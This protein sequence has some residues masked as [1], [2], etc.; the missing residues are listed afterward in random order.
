M[1]GF[2]QKKRHDQTDEESSPG[3]GLILGYGGM[4]LLWCGRGHCALSSGR[5]ESV[6]LFFYVIFFLTL[7]CARAHL[8]VCSPIPSDRCGMR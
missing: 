2:I 4:F 3:A 5:E 1:C 7:L 6:S 8:G